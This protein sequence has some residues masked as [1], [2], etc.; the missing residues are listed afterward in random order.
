M[1]GEFGAHAHR[2]RQFANGV[3]LAGMVAGEGIDRHHR[4]EA[5]GAYV[6]NLLEQVGA[7][8]AHLIGGFRQQRGGQR[9]AGYHLV[10]AAVVFHGPHGYHQHRRIRHEARGPALDVEEALGAHVGSEPRLGDHEIAGMQ[11]DVV[12]DDRGVAMRDVAEG[13]GVYQ[14][15]GVFE[16]LQQVGLEGFLEQHRHGTGGTNLLGGDRRAAA[17]QAHDHPA[18]APTQIDQRVCQCQHRHHLRGGGDL[19]AAL[20]G[21]AVTAPAEA[22]DQMP[23]GAV[24][25]VNDPL[26]AYLARI[27]LGFQTVV[28]VIVDHGGQQVVS[29]PHRVYVASQVQ[30]DAFHGQ[31]LA[32]A[33]AGGASLEAQGRPHG[34]LAQGHGSGVAEP[35]QPLD[36]ADGGG[37][38]ALA[39]RRRGHRGDHHVA[40][41]WTLGERRHGRQVELGNATAIGLHGLAG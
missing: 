27:Q 7:A 26:P 13:A 34:G 18:Q 8:F 35:L 32:V 24:V 40:S 6:V 22:H 41:A 31:D 5:V 15:R 4:V 30:V 19:E 16:G 2:G 9:L 3:D 28:E 11:A 39:G 36:Q 12:G 1:A 14:R 10:A 21:N 37:G 33:A 29:R 38:L 17:V 25:E 20:A 23:Q